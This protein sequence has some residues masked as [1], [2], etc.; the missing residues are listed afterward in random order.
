M[1]RG[2]RGGA[3]PEDD[4][5]YVDVAA[6]DEESP[7]E[8]SSYAPDAVAASPVPPKRRRWWLLPWLGV[9][10]LIGLII[11][12]Y[13]LGGDNTQTMT[14]PHPTGAALASAQASAAA[15]NEKKITELKEKVGADPTNV[16]ALLE[17]GVALFDSG[18]LAGAEI[19]WTKASEVDPKNVMAH[20]NLGFL[21]LSKQPPE[22][23]KTEYHWEQVVKLDPDSELAANVKKHLTRMSA[24]PTPSASPRK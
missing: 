17:L 16:D 2:R 24:S 15:E 5:T 3:R 18:D 8:A 23:A 21:Y 6:F 20:Y 10:V 14:A 1:L 4:G 19:N 12:A 7:A 13:Y 9:G 11:S 22:R